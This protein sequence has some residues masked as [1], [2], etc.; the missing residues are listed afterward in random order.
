MYVPDKGDIVSLDFNVNVEKERR[1]SRCVLVV[2]RKRFN[3]H[4]GLVI[5]VPITHVTRGIKLEVVLP[6]A[7][8]T[9]GS[10]LVH[11]VKSID[12]SNRQVN[13]I[14]KAPQSITDKV[15]ELTKIIIS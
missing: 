15:T 14:E 5:V 11:Q 10:I 2:S 1:K 12:L 13:F 8:S 7:L 6:K 9:Q 3:E 4:T